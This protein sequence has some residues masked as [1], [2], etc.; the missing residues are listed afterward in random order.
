MAKPERGIPSLMMMPTPLEPSAA[1]DDQ[2]GATEQGGESPATAPKPRARRR[3]IDPGEKTRGHK[4]SLPDAVFERL[5]LTAIRR[6]SS[7]SAIAAEIL[8]RNL[9]RLRIEQ[10]G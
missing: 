5:E 3:R 7:V 6:R 9:P 8:D 4:L 1:V 2:G 10:D